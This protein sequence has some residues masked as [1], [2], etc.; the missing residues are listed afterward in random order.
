MEPLRPTAPLR[1]DFAGPDPRGAWVNPPP[2][3]RFAAG[4][5]VETGPRT[6]FWQRTHY[7]FRRDDGH[8]WALLVA[9]DFT[10]ETRARWAPR[11]R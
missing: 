2:S 9:G 4:L 11:A 5:H 8:V 10:V 1:L 7:G 3:H 6:D